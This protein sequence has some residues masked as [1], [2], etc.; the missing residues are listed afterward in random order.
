MGSHYIPVG[1][2]KIDKYLLDIAC[3]A[4]GYDG[5]PP[6]A[7]IFCPANG[8]IDPNDPNNPYVP[9]FPPYEPELGMPEVDPNEIGEGEIL[10]I[11][12]NEL[13]GEVRLSITRSTGNLNWWIYGANDS[14]L[15]SGNTSSISPTWN[16]NNYSGGFLTLSGLSVFKLV[17][18]PASGTF[19]NCSAFSTSIVYPIKEVYV[20]AS[21]LQTFSFRNQSLIEKVWFFDVMNS[22][23]GSDYA[24]AG[25][26]L[27]KDVTLPTTMN[28]MVLFT[29][30]FYLSG[31]PKCKLPT[32]MEECTSI[33]GIFNL[34][35]VKEFTLPTNCPKLWNLRSLASQ[36]KNLISLIFPESFSKLPLS[37]WDMLTGSNVKYLKLHSEFKASAIYCAFQNT[38]NMDTDDHV[39][40]LKCV[41]VTS[42][43]NLLTF[44]NKIKKVV[45][46]GNCIVDNFSFFSFNSSSVLEEVVLYTEGAPNATNMITPFLNNYKVKK[47]TPPKSM[48]SLTG[49]LTLNVGAAS[50]PNLEVFEKIDSWGSSPIGISVGPNKI[51]VFDQ[52]ALNASSLTW[53]NTVLEYINI[54]WS[55][56]TATS[57]TLRNNQL[58]A[59]ELNRIFGL[60]PISSGRTIY[61][62]GNPGYLSCDPSIAAARGWTVAI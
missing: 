3:P 43:Q 54:N 44:N 39:L 10:L 60:L 37:I 58:S 45:L 33:E 41:D 26:P 11:C 48:P 34:S 59:T 5:T 57:I 52:P 1:K 13:I 29:R 20:K 12:S 47:Y 6:P 27:L 16:F 62:S 40:Y 38:P 55:T 30:W 56:Y 32:N 61:C 21:T 25:T 53:Q 35:E 17:L 46:D 42:H 14:L 15:D 4:A 28:A 22:L 23:I 18:K 31:I 49:S 2:L 51:K 8:Y 7:E 36:T 19:I 24:L 50:Y 9:V